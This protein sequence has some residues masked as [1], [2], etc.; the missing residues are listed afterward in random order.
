MAKVIAYVRVPSD[1][2]ADSG[3]DL[4]VQ[5]SAILAEAERPG[6]AASPQGSAVQDSRL[7]SEPTI[8]TEASAE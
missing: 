6:S 3:A 8:V 1:E 4:E 2:R 7:I 5:R